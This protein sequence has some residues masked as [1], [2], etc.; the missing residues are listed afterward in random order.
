MKAK[1]LVAAALACGVAWALLVGG[2]AVAE[3]TSADA[4]EPVRIE[5]AAGDV[6]G[7]DGPDNAPQQETE[8]AEPSI[9]EALRAQEAKSAEEEKVRA[10]AEAQAKAEEIARVVAELEAKA[11]AEEAAEQQAAQAAANDAS[12][13]ASSSY[14][15]AYY[16]SEPAYYEP[17]PAYD[18][19]PAYVEEA[20]TPA[21][22]PEPAPA[23]ASMPAQTIVVDGVA[24]SYIYSYGWVPDSGAGVWKGSDSTTDGSY[25]YFVGH[26][27]GSFW[28][29]ASIGIGGAITV[30]DCDGNCRTYYVVETF[31][32]PVGST[33]NDVCDA[34]Y[35]YGESVTLQ[36]CVDSG[37]RIV[38]AA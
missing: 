10:E 32:V 37:Y 17:E 15:T 23:P 34:V 14:E 38:V 21:S 5:A 9:L 11:T 33:W 36:T 26:N 13:G 18:P 8:D 28:P 1:K 2:A 16:E 29:A 19:E 25:G 24:I 31:V 7:D 27:P 22:E 12:C 35:R 6:A 3:S 4:A 20:P 30:Y